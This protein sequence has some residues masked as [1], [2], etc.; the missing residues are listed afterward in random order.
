[1]RPF[2][3]IIVQACNRPDEPVRQ[4]SCKPTSRM[5]FALHRATFVGRIS[6]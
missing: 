3:D 1:M 6:K 2:P 5:P 4:A